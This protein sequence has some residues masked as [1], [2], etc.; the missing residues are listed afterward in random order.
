MSKVTFNHKKMEP[1]W[2]QYWSEHNTFKTTED[3]N[4][5]NFYALDM[6]P[7]PSG[8]GL[9]VGHPEGYTATDILSR[10]KR[11]QGFQQNNMRLILEMTQKNLPRLILQTLLAKLNH[12]VFPT[13]G[14][15]KSIQQILNIINGHSGFLKNYMKMA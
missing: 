5:E 8:A 14:I 12:L 10:M 6:F 2:Q 3:K 4:K 13:I 15:V 7:Y 11:M 9:H 1:K